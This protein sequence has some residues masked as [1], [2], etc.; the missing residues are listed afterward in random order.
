MKSIDIHATESADKPLCKSR[1]DPRLGPTRLS[2]R[3][4][5]AA[6]NG[7]HLRSEFLLGNAKR[8][9]SGISSPSH[10]QEDELSL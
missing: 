9:Q 2:M 5:A 7:A 6:P 10:E 1:P 4:P 3:L 8:E